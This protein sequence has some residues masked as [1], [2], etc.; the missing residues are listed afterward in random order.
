VRVTVSVIGS[1][2]FPAVL[3]GQQ[4]DTLRCATWAACAPRAALAW[5]TSNA[6][7]VYP[8][9]MHTVGID[10]LADVTF[11]VLPNGKLDEGTIRFAIV[12]N[13]AFEHAMR[14]AMQGWRFRVADTVTSSISMRL[15]THF[16]RADRCTTAEQ[17]R[18]SL[19]H[20]EGVKRLVVLACPAR[21]I[22]RD[23]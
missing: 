14:V 6:A 23:G 13:R 7:P 9:A 1:L 4:P 22:P 17:V 12:T 5:D 19:T 10:G 8:P 21:I 15:I 11:S 20:W 16:I 3:A 2:L 18:T